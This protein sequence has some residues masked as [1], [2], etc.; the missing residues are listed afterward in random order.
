M[1]NQYANAEYEPKVKELKAELQRL[2]AEYDV[3]PEE[4]TSSQPRKRSKPKGTA[5]SN[6]TRN[7][8]P[9]R[10]GKIRNL[11]LLMSDDL[12]ASALSVYGNKVCKTPSLDRLAAS[13]TKPGKTT[14][15]AEL[16]DFYPTTTDLL[17]KR[18]TEPL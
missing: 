11:L 4:P 10:S 14:S 8:E 7:A 5:K 12:K 18:S 2:R 9:E 3:A 15:M 16:A 17:S 6:P 13:G 1:S